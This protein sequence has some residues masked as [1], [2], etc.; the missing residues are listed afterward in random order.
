MAFKNVHE[1]CAI[2]D[3]SA[4]PVD[5]EKISTKHIKSA[6]IEELQADLMYLRRKG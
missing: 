6:L 3:S 1:V 5:K 2:C 4:R